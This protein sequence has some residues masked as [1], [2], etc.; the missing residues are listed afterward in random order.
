[1]GKD[2]PQ[3]QGSDPRLVGADIWRHCV[4]GAPSD[5]LLSAGVSG[6]VYPE[7]RAKA[8]EYSNINGNLLFP[9]KITVLE[10]REDGGVLIETLYGFLGGTISME[11]DGPD[12]LPSIGRPMF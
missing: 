1:M 5:Y 9:V 12:G 6:G 2:K 4:L 3:S 11:Y 7:K 8:I 10:V